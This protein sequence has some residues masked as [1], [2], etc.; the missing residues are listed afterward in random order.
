MREA[1]WIFNPPPLPSPPH[2]LPN[3]AN[4]LLSTPRHPHHATP[5][6]TTTPPQRIAVVTV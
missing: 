1:S 6:T 3:R 4:P 2:L 5:P